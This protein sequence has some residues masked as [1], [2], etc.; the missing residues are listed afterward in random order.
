MCHSSSPPH[1]WVSTL[2]TVVILNTGSRAV[3]DPAVLLWVCW[4]LAPVIALR[5]DHVLQGPWSPG[6]PLQ[7]QGQELLVASQPMSRPCEDHLATGSSLPWGSAFHAWCPAPGRCLWALS[8]PPLSPHFT[9]PPEMLWSSRS[10]AFPVSPG[11]WA[12]ALAGPA[13]C[14]GDAEREFGGRQ[15]WPPCPDPPCCVLRVSSAPHHGNDCQLILLYFS[16]ADQLLN[17]CK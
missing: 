10:A 3:E 11:R 17:C 16:D 14:R 1:S 4:F 2:Q 12:G 6:L 9:A 15:L 5:E 8:S 7:L 13:G